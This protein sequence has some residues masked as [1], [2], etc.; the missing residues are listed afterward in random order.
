MKAQPKNVVMGIAV[1]LIFVATAVVFVLAHLQGEPTLERP[2]YRW[3]HMPLTV[4]CFAYTGGTDG[5]GVVEDAIELVNDRLRFQ[6]LEYAPGEGLTDITV[7][8]GVPQEVPQDGQSNPAPFEHSGGN[9]F[10]RRSEASLRYT[11]CEINTINVPFRDLRKYILYHEF[12]HCLG[13]AHDTYPI[14]IMNPTTA[15]PEPGRFAP[16]FSEDDR[17]AIRER[18]DIE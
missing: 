16:W 7:N 8:L 10:L 14:S 13:L 12:G 2:E 15:R 4:K 17:D 11:S 9:F 18:Y 1:V 6:A 5:C 3:D